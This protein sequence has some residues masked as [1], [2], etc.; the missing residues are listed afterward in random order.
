MKDI[1]VLN[2]LLI[3]SRALFRAVWVLVT[4]YF[5]VPTYLVSAS[6]QNGAIKV[7]VV[8]SSLGTKFDS[9]VSM[10]ISPLVLT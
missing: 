10:E 9:T 3:S 6:P 7:P 2:A 1:A 4:P 8:G 5:T